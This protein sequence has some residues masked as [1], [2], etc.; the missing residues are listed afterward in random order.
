MKSRSF[1]QRLLCSGKPSLLLESEKPCVSQEIPYL[2]VATFWSAQSMKRQSLS[3][4]GFLSDTCSGFFDL[5]SLNG[6]GGNAAWKV[7]SKTHALHL[8]LYDLRHV[9][10]PFRPEYCIGRHL[11]PTRISV[12]R[13]IPCFCLYHEEL[14]TLRQR[15]SNLDS[16]KITLDYTG[17]L[18]PIR[19]QTS[20]R[21]YVESIVFMLSYSRVSKQESFMGFLRHRLQYGCILQSFGPWTVSNISAKWKTQA[22]ILQAE[23]PFS[24]SVCYLKEKRLYIWTSWFLDLR[25]WSDLHISF[26]R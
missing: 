19:V 14:Q 1:Y 2:Q 9:F 22:A 13:K 23:L 15:G 12:L 20:G 7:I 6:G 3:S 24:K 8:K 17:Q 18:S 11:S 5:L 25:I 16:F 21:W 10:L 26:L 4:V